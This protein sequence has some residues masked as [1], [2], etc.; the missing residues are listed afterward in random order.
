MFRLIGPSS[1][2]KYACLIKLLFLF[3]LFIYLLA[4]SI[5]LLVILHATFQ[6]ISSVYYN[7]R[8]FVYYLSLSLIHSSHCFG[9][10][11]FVYSFCKFCQ[12]FIMFFDEHVFF[13]GPV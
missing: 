7:T 11:Y 6:N 9:L 12:C 5:T 3:F 2:R 13:Y 10:I 8:T 4:C 1:W